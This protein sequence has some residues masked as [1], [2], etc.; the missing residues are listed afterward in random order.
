MAVSVR[1]VAALA[2]VSVG[3]VSNVLNRPEKV[4]DETV[5]RVRVAIAQLGFVR[6]DAARQ[7]RAGRSRSV[8]LIVLDVGN[9][10]FTDL[11]RGAE[12]QAARVGLSVLLGNSDENAARE[13]AYL[14]L[15]EAQQVTGVLISPLDDASQRLERLR[16]RGIPTVLVDRPADTA[17]FSSVSVDDVLG[18]RL[19]LEH[20]IEIGCSRVAFVG[21]P[22][23]IRQVSDRLEGA[24]RAVAAGSS[25][26]L[27][28]IDTESLSV[29]QG[30]RAALSIGERTADE[31]PDA[32]FAAN[33][34][35]ALGVLQGLAASGIRVPDDVAVIGYDDIEFAE[36]AS[37][38]LSSVK[39]PARLIGE[40]ALQLLLDEIA[41]GEGFEH[42][43]VRFEPELV[44]RDSTSIRDSQPSRAVR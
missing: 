40:A 25:V 18:G 20:L 19:A 8:G 38:S 28:V 31:R 43:H 7:L 4:A 24:R 32:V 42:R 34:L 36:S 22:R 13:S 11:A 9:P 5:E 15:F 33:D 44:V 27:E 1:E 30:R 2:G 17:R 12:D 29:L 16:A 23:H 14:D 37:V 41:A 6:N 3:T 35:L 10:F 21:G 26:Q 39:Q